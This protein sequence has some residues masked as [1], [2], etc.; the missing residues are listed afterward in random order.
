MKKKIFVAILLIVI[1]LFV[2]WYG[3]Q[4]RLKELS[5]WWAKGPIIV[6]K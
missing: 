5:L 1:A 2:A 6:N 3:Y 4:E